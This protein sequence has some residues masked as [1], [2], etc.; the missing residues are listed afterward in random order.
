LAI[1][2]SK[3]VVDKG[4][5]YRYGIGAGIA[6]LC[7]YFKG[8]KETKEKEKV[9]FHGSIIWYKWLIW[10]LFRVNNCVTRHDLVVLF[11]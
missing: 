8:K 11:F 1:T 5:C 3:I 4:Q 9:V 7:V 10:G 2:G 6:R